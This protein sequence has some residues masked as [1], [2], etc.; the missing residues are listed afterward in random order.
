MIQVPVS[1]GELLDKITI[2]RIKSERIAD[3]EKVRNVKK[4]LALLEDA[5]EKGL[6]S[7][8]VDA[9]VEELKAVNERLWDIEEEIRQC[10]SKADFGSRFVEL[11]RSVY[12]ENDQRGAIKRQINQQ[13]GSDLI[14]EKDYSTAKPMTG[15]DACRPAVAR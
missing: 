6:P 8:S 15:Y 11:A 12:H 5:R 1:F 14:E 13:L 4:E 10:E 7:R 2:L 3:P 9:L